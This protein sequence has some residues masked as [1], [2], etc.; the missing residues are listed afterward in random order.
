MIGVWCIGGLGAPR[1]EMGFLNAVLVIAENVLVVYILCSLC[2]SV[3]VLGF[4][5]LPV[6]CCSPE[7]STLQLVIG[8]VQMTEMMMA[9]GDSFC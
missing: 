3:F 4:L 6:P 5:S 2:F 9:G 8:I 7:I 1:V